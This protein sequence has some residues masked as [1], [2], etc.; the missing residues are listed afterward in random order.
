VKAKMLA[1]LFR[2]PVD[3]LFN[4]DWDEARAAGR[5]RGTWLLV[6]LQ[7]IKEFACQ[8]LNRDVWSSPAVQDFVRSN[9]LFWQM[10]HDSPEGARVC[11][12][13]NVHAFPV[14]LIVDPRTG[15]KVAELKA[16]GDHAHYLDQLT[17]FHEK[18]PNFES[19]DV[20]YAPKTLD[21][22]AIISPR[23]AKRSASSS[24]TDAETDVQ[25]KR[26]R[27]VVIISDDDEESE[28][29]E[30]VEAAPQ[31]EY[32]LGGS[33]RKRAPAILTRRRR[34]VDPDEWKHHI[35]EHDAATPVH[36]VV[37][38][39]N[40]ER[41]SMRLF[42]SSKLKAIFLFIGGLGLPMHEHLLVLNH[43]KRVFS[44]NEQEKTLAEAGFSA[45]ELI[46]LE[47]I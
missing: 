39:V 27:R 17:S 25:A 24:T 46:Y 19:N 38:L 29:T 33:P 11:G 32:R 6:N 34:T 21:K 37:R 35:D 8:V 36:L 1:D 18:F 15:E 10:S 5:E 44:F 42:D 22:P 45:Q 12:Y 23:A 40:G 4:G 13:Y 7:D 2:P 47:S 30:S 41:K 3:L 16:T 9:F 31:A 14:I 20:H 26:M 28:G 43:P